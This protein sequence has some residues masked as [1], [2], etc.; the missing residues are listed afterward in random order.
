MKIFEIEI[1]FTKD[2]DDLQSIKLYNFSQS[3]K[4]K[5]K[6]ISETDKCGVNSST[7]VVGQ[8]SYEVPSYILFWHVTVPCFDIY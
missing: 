5:K 1:T 4:K 3:R 2:D 6:K 7:L 8:Y